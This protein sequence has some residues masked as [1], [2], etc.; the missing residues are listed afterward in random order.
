MPDILVRSKVERFAGRGVSG[1]GGVR[2]LL[3]T[4]MS[5]R[6]V[7][8]RGRIPKAL[9]RRYQ[10]GGL[11][12]LRYVPVVFPLYLGYTPVLLPALFGGPHAGSIAPWLARTARSLDVNSL[13]SFKD[14]SFEPRHSRTN[15]A[16]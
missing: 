16:G 10:P 14:F 3:R 8:G 2:E 7:A 13:V 11:E 5:A 1:L 9:L 15:W 12:T 4:G 6:R